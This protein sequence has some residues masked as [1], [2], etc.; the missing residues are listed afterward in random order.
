LFIELAEYLR[1]PADHPE[2]HCVLSSD[3]MDGRDVVRG[4]VGCPVCR[5]EYPIADRIAHFGEPPS[6]RSRGPVPEAGILQ[7]LLGISTPGGYLVLIG[8]AATRAAELAELIYGVHLVGVNAAPNV[9]PGRGISLMVAAASV[10]LR[11]AM[12]RG[13][14]VGEEAA[15]SPWL[16]EG[17]RVLLPGLRILVLAGALEVPGVERLAAEQGM[18]V[19]QKIRDRK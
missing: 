14:I 7:A 17:A 18:W 1:C 15:V 16:A 9:R 5:S 11:S 3:A 8:S 2:A 10:P 19:G 12:A 13:V 4:I 6:I